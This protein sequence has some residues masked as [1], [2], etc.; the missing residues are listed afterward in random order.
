MFERVTKEFANLDDRDRVLYQW[1]WTLADLGKA[2]ES[3]EVFEQLRKE[4]PHSRYWADATYRILERAFAAKE[5]ARSRKLAAALLAA[6]PA[7]SLRESTMLVQGQIEA[8]EGK[9]KE[10]RRRFRR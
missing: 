2:G 6:K 4:Y 7:A 5:F 3:A 8:A 10:A 9:W 1:A